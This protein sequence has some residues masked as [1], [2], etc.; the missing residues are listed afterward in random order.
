MLKLFGELFVWLS[1]QGALFLLFVLEGFA[2]PFGTK[3]GDIAFVQFDSF[4][5]SSGGVACI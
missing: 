3:H 4:Q 5:R 2:L 1:S